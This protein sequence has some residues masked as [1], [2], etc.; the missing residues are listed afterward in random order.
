MGITL[1]MKSNQALPEIAL[2]GVGEGQPMSEAEM[3]SHFQSDIAAACARAAAATGEVK[4]APPVPTAAR[5]FRVAHGRG[6]RD[7]AHGE[8]HRATTCG[9]AC[10]GL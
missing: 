5:I 3:Q 6:Q 2:D 8:P 7:A 9:A 10:R 1:S 4:S